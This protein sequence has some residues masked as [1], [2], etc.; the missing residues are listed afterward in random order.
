MGLI[1]KYMLKKKP[2]AD[3]IETMLLPVIL[4]L[5]AG[6]TGGMIAYSYFTIAL[7]QV[8]NTVSVGRVVAAVTA[9]LPESQIAERLDAVN[10]PIFKKSDV[11]SGDFANRVLR[12]EDAIG[13]ATVL[14]S[15]GWL[16]SHKNVAAGQ[17]LVGLDGELKEPTRTIFD[18]R[19][20]VVFLK[21]ENGPLQVTDFEETEFLDKGVPLFALSSETG[22]TRTSFGGARLR[23]GLTVS[24]SDAFNRTFTLQDDFDSASYGG[25]VL[26]LG[27]NLAGII[28]EDG[29]VP[30]H[31]IRPILSDAF[32]SQEL[33]RGKLGV[34]Y[35]NLT[36]SYVSGAATESKSGT[37]LTGSRLRGLSA[38]RRGSAAAIAGLVEGDIILRIEDIELSSGRDLAETIAEYRPGDMIEL[39]ILRG[40]ERSLVEVKL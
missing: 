28:S 31:L 25:A 6:V 38:V 33:N 29:F 39:E 20:G 8:S 36:T 7:Y 30:V 19:T 11:G 35:L 3:F 32:R 15:D 34:R 10:L 21:V 16:M 22:F 37:R 40:G 1:Q 26:T 5:A 9:P 23:D 27:G 12:D 17:I 13:M 14:T 18:K 24:D 4:G 2:L